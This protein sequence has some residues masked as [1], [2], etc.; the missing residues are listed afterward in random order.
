MHLESVDAATI[1]T[2]RTPL[3]L[4]AN[5]HAGELLS[6]QA[7]EAGFLWGRDKRDDSLWKLENDEARDHRAH[8]KANVV[9]P[10][11]GC[12]ANL[13]TVHSTTRR[14]HL[15]HLA[16]GGGHGLE[17]LFHAQGCAVVESWLRSKY[18]GYLVKREEYSNDAGE[19]RADVMITS[20]R[21]A[22]VAFEVQYS[23]ITPDAWITRHESYR[24]Q[25]I[26]DVWLFGHSSNHLRRAEDGQL[27]PLS[28][29]YTVVEMGM[30]LLFINPTTEVVGL[31]C[32]TAQILNPDT[33]RYENYSVPVLTSIEKARLVVD[34]L[35]TYRVEPKYGITSDRLARYRQATLHVPEANGAAK[36]VVAA[37]K[38]ARELA[39]D[40]KQRAWEA[41]RGPQQDAIRQLLAARQPWFELGGYGITKLS[42]AHQA[43]AE[44]FGQ[45]LRDRID[46][47]TPN[48]A[49]RPDSHL[50]Q[51]QCV[52]YFILIAGREGK[53]FTVPDAHQAA[54]MF[55]PSIGSKSEYKDVGRWLWRL[56]AAG[57]LRAVK[58]KGDRYYAFLPTVTGAWW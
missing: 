32:S 29:H 15:R 4:A 9:C 30:P 51:W 50:N 40:G 22:R 17:S 42:S 43:I 7:G 56:D 34:S 19:R 14:D 26:A 58:G 57:Y 18:P 48:P 53:P 47:V 28:V 41:R 39:R 24:R 8:V 12:A 44:Y 36:E 21:G 49:I 16:A 38:I 1:R 25:D 10:V 3:V 13:T 20:P 35:D 23:P 37:A 45:Y 27:M 33:E 46:T 5:D 11:P 6:A 31:A 52:I 55:A 54:K 2:W